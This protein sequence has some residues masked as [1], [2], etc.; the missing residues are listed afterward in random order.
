MLNSRQNSVTDDVEPRKVEP[1]KDPLGKL[2]V[3]KGNPHRQLWQDYIAGKVSI[4][5]L[6]KTLRGKLLKSVYKMKKQGYPPE[7]TVRGL[8][9]SGMEG[10]MQGWGKA[11]NKVDCVNIGK[12]YW[13]GILYKD[14]VEGRLKAEQGKEEEIEELLSE[15]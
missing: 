3:K 9:K 15:W 5:E 11:C 8:S 7:P 4:D 12:K 2:M 14:V 6:H 1:V 13:L 10:I